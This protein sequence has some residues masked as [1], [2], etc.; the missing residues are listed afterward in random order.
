ME[1]KHFNK[2]LLL[3]L[4]VTLDVFGKL[5]F[6]PPKG[7]SLR[8]YLRCFLLCNYPHVISYLEKLFKFQ[9]F[10]SVFVV[11]DYSSTPDTPWE[12][13]SHMKKQQSHLPNPP[14]HTSNFLP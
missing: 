2:E 5:C 6:F 10:I 7:G 8:E 14:F 4:L 1:T 11:S 9:V 3:Q 13:I 12:E